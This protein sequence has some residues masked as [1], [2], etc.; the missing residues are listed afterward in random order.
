MIT[1]GRLAVKKS[2]LTCIF[3]GKY[4]SKMMSVLRIEI[5]LSGDILHGALEE[6]LLGVLL[7][8]KRT[9]FLPKTMPVIKTKFDRC[10]KTPK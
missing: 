4:L 7:K 6:S 10:Q 1:R 9:I 5:P 3:E 8:R 2:S